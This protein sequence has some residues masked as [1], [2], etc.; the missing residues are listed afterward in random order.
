MM[1][2]YLQ[3]IADINPSFS[4][5]IYQTGCHYII[6]SVGSVDRQT[7]AITNSHIVLLGDTHC[8]LAMYGNSNV[9]CVCFDCVDSKS[10]KGIGLI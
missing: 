7:C 8:T 4:L 6:K 9:T 3:S 1:L 10:E 2:V 5:E